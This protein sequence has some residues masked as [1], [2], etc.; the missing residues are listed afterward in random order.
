[1]PGPNGMMPAPA[2]WMTAVLVAALLVAAG[3]CGRAPDNPPPSCSDLGCT[4]EEGDY[5]HSVIDARDGERWV[6]FDLETATVVSPDD[7]STDPVWD[8]SFQRVVIKSNGGINGSANVEVAILDETTLEEVTT[9][10]SSGWGVDE[11]GGGNVRDPGGSR[12]NSESWY[13]YDLISH[14]LEPVEDRVYVVRTGAGSLFKLR[15]DGYYSAEAES[16][17]VSFTWSTVAP[18]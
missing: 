9:A 7:P 18:F 13:V 2:R 16:G 14:T 11:E 5:L 6:H 3:G 4:V 12:F 10:P 8:L 1:M 17:W 15:F